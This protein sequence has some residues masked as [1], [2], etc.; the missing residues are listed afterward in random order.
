[1]VC[2]FEINGDQKKIFFVSD[3]PPLSPTLFR[4]DLA[5]LSE[6]LQLY[7]LSY[8]G[9]HSLSGSNRLSYTTHVFPIVLPDLPSLTRYNASSFTIKL[10][11]GVFIHPFIGCCCQQRPHCPSCHQLEV[12]MGTCLHDLYHHLYFILFQSYPLPTHPLP[13][14]ELIEARRRRKRTPPRN[15]TKFRQGIG[16]SYV[17]F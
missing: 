10:T 15:C 1:M 14:P 13:S 12:R 16:S 8:R 2:A 5:I 7:P 4:F 3:N 9:C 11:I 17:L 6:S